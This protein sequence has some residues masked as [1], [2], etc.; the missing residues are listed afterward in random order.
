MA[1]ETKKIKIYKPTDSVIS[2][3]C[4]WIYFPVKYLLMGKIQSPKMFIFA[5]DM[6]IR[7]WVKIHFAF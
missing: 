5:Q 6:G 3:R 4:P 7:N 2:K 1:N